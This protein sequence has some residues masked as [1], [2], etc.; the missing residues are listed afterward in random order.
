MPN[1][2]PTPT[3]TPHPNPNPDQV[4]THF[5]GEQKEDVHYSQITVLQNGNADTRRRLAV[6]CLKDAYL[7]Q[8]LLDKLMCATN[9]TETANPNPYPNPNPTPNQVRDQLHGDGQP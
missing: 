8:R 6:Y 9:S 7:P 2:T 3:P 4:S 1:P 5:L